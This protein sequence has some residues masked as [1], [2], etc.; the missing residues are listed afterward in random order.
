LNQKPDNCEILLKKKKEEK[1]RLGVNTVKNGRKCHHLNPR[2]KL[3]EK[4]QQKNWQLGRKSA[5]IERQTIH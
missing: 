4:G 5:N 1:N 2:N 3:Q